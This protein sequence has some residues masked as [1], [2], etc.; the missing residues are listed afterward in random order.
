MWVRVRLARPT[1]ELAVRL[2]VARTPAALRGSDR[3]TIVRQTFSK[4]SEKQKGKEKE[5]VYFFL[6]FIR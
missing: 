4:K 5:I 6:F 3:L 1:L 2:A